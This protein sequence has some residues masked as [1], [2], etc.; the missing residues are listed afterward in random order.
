V[1]AGPRDPLSQ[2]DGD[3]SKKAGSGSELT[4][5]AAAAPSP[6]VLAAVPLVVTISDPGGAAE[7]TRAGTAVAAPRQIGRRRQ[8]RTVASGLAHVPVS[9]SIAGPVPVQG[10]ASATHFQQQVAAGVVCSV[11]KV[12]L[13]DSDTWLECTSLRPNCQRKYHITCV[14]AKFSHLYRTKQ[15]EVPQ[16]KKAKWR[17]MSCSDMCAVCVPAAKIVANQPFYNCCNC[18]SKAHQD[19]WAKGGDKI[20]FY[21][22]QSM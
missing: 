12:D 2:A 4:V 3:A 22:R 5:A 8:E 17:C 10:Q 13:K 20:C 14:V 16:D 18:G 1:C 9:A 15:L 19:H 6:S 21:C 7:R 11:C